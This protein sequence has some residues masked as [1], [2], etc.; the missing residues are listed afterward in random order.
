MPKKPVKAEEY[1][2]FAAE[3]AALAVASSLNHLREKHLNAALQWAVLAAK[4]EER[5][6]P[7]LAL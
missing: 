4:E 5:R 7:A 2:R 6:L 3:A 1:R